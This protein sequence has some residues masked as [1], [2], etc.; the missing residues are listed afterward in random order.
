MK[1]FVALLFSVVIAFSC[2]HRF[3]EGEYKKV[4]RLGEYE[5]ACTDNV[6]QD[7][8][9]NPNAWGGNFVLV[10]K[11][12]YTYSEIRELFEH[13]SDEWYEAHIRNTGKMKIEAENKCVIRDMAINTDTNDLWLWVQDETTY[14]KSEAEYQEQIERGNNRLNSI[15]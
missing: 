7:R 8:Y 4:I 9:D 6:Y 1:R 15:K 12:D 5:F 3:Q 14:A 13:M 2:N 10:K 11:D